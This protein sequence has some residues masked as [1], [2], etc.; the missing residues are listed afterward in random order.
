MADGTSNSE[1]WF[2]PNDPDQSADADVAE[3]R[4]QGSVFSFLHV[5]DLL[6]RGYHKNG[7]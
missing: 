1:N 6:E 7:L 3:E 4:M 2:D 5:L